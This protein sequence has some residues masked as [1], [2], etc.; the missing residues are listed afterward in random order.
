MKIREYPSL[1]VSVGTF[2]P[3]ERR[4]KVIKQVGGLPLGQ[5]LFDTEEMVQLADAVGTI[6]E[7]T[8]DRI[9]DDAVKLGRDV[10]DTAAHAMI[11][12]ACQGIREHVDHF[13][14]NAA[15]ALSITGTNLLV[16]RLGEDGLNRILQAHGEEAR[17]SGLGAML[18][19]MS[20]E[21]LLALLAALGGGRR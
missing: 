10:N 6:V 2:T 12:L 3:E 8:M 16:E 11:F 21:Q 9:M 15:E 20:P 17:G 19:H 13:A 5:H 4:A 18:S 14:M 1:G 7:D